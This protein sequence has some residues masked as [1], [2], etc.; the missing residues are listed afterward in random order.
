VHCTY[1]PETRGGNAGSSAAFDNRKVKGTIHWVSTAGALPIEVRVYDYLF[2]TERP[3]DA[4]PRP[5]GSPG[6]FTDNIN[7]NSLEVI[8]GAW[9]E[10]CLAAPAEQVRYQFERLGYFVR[11]ID[12]GADGRPVF[13]KTI[14]LRDTWA[15]I[16][17]K[18]PN[19]KA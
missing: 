4:A 17:N 14:G 6:E 1:D 16:A 5:D 13:N 3:M 18:E 7:P 8:T 12:S 19:R 15:K 2:N 10:P 9:A 11:D